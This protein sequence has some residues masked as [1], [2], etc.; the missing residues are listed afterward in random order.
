M[1]LKLHYKPRT[2]YWL[3]PRT[4]TYNLTKKKNTFCVKKC[5][6]EA[7]CT[8]LYYYWIQTAELR[9]FCFSLCLLLPS[10]HNSCCFFSD[11]HSVVPKEIVRS[12]PY[13]VCVFFFCFFFNMHNSRNLQQCIRPNTLVLHLY[14]SSDLTVHSP[15]LVYGQWP[16]WKVL[17]ARRK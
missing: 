7:S 6:Y 15:Q 3:L 17:L 13:S 8:I 5:D 10:A 2:Q 4:T 12:E 9:L 11:S 16:N 14:I 1:Y